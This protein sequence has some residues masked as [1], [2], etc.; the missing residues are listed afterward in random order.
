MTGASFDRLIELSLPVFNNTMLVHDSDFNI[1]AFASPPNAQFPNDFYSLLNE[2][3]TFPSNF[4]E[5]FMRQD[6]FS[7]IVQGKTAGVLVR[8][9]EAFKTVSSYINIPLTDDYIVRISIDSTNVPLVFGRPDQVEDACPG[10]TPLR[11]VAGH[12]RAPAPAPPGC[13]AA[14]PG[15]EHAGGR[16]GARQ[17]DA[18]VRLE[19]TKT[20]TCA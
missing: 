7:R 12:A 13:L 15:R 5:E 3:G 14:R 10:H 19:L 2:S 6:S 1:V 11:S 17:A 18:P 4:L 8:P 9:E 16:R 20:S